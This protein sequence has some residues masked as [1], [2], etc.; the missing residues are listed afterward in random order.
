[1][2]GRVKK[3]AFCVRPTVLPRCP[4][5]LIIPGMTYLPVNSTIWAPAGIRSSVTGPTHDDTAGVENHRGAGERR[6]AAAVDQGEVPQH[7]D[8]APE[9]GGAKQQR[10]ETGGFT[11]LSCGH[12]GKPPD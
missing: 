1:M 8:L 12:I 2:F 6:V 9:R 11:S 4:C 10:H 7:L 3:L 5:R